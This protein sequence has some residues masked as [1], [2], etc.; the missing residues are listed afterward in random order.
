MNAKE[1]EQLKNTY[2]EY[3]ANAKPGTYYI[4]LYKQNEGKTLVI[5]ACR[6][7]DLL[8]CDLYDYF[9]ARVTTKHY[10]KQVRYAF[11]KYMKEVKPKVYGDCKYAIVI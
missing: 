3:M 9:G 1:K 11:L 8:S 2:K 4:G 7:K 5:E 10:M 6:D